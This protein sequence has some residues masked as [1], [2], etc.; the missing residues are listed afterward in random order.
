MGA[1]VPILSLVSICAVTAVYA[2]GYLGAS[3]S[4]AVTLT[5]WVMSL[6]SRMLVDFLRELAGAKEPERTDWLLIGND[7]SG[8]AIV[9]RPMS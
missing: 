4:V 8:E 2:A 9:I 1:V 3:G 6:Y 7:P 5:A